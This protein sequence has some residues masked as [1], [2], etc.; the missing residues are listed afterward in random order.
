MGLNKK[1]GEGNGTKT[2]PDTLTST[3]MALGL[4]L[5]SHFV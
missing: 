5:I 3:F 4:V 2:L 1:V